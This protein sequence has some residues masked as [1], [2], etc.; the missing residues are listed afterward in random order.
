MRLDVVADGLAEPGAKTVLVGATRPGGYAVDVAAQVLLGGFCPLQDELDLDAV[1]L[2]E[3][4]RRLVHGPGALLADDLLQIVDE[5]FLVL[6]HVPPAARLVFE[7]H[8]HAAVQVAGD[9]EP[10]ADDRRVEF[11]LWKNLRVGLE[12]DGGAR[13]PRRT[14][15]LQGA[16]RLS[17]PE[18]HLV[19]KPVALDGGD[20]LTRQRV[21]HARADPVEAAGRLV[22]A[23][24]ELAARV[25]HREDHLEGALLRLGMGVDRYAAA[26]VFDGDRRAVLVE[27]HANVRRVAIHGLVDGVV[28]RFPDQVMEARAA[29]AA[30]VHAWALA[31]R[32]EAFEHGNVLGG[33]GGGHSSRD[34]I[35]RALIKILRSADYADY[36]DAE[37]PQR[38]ALPGAMR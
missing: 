16:R 13:A 24:L 36:A 11:D 8:L 15:L 34:Y 3:R 26:V 35:A 32:L 29:D 31:N 21:D 6:K 30:D 1:L 20:E 37:D 23:G 33:I 5:A 7:G 14:D 12:E 22:V 19:L 38:R 10:F 27:G 9:L 17:L 28:E 18:G 25:E 2:L 4:E